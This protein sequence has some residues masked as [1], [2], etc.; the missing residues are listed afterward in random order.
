M[1]PAL[2]DD[3]LVSLRAWIKG[4]WCVKFQ[5]LFQGLGPFWRSLRFCMTTSRCLFDTQSQT[6]GG[7]LR[8]FGHHHVQRYGRGF[9]YDVR[10]VIALIGASIL[11]RAL[12]SLTSSATPIA[13]QSNVVLMMCLLIAELAA[14]AAGCYSCNRGLGCD[15]FMST[16][17][18]ALLLTS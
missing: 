3:P 11:H 2:H 8:K 13:E 16:T 5:V 18:L 7:V 9:W 1:S 10:F 12:Y 4:F 15:E 14:A 6:A 17:V